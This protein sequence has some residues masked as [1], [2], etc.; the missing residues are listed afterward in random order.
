MLILDN[1]KFS[2][3]SVGELSTDK[4]Y[5]HMKRVMKS[6]EVIFVTNGTLYMEED[7]IQYAL[8]PN[9]ILVLEPDKFHRGY[10]IHEGGTAFYWFH[11]RT[12]NL[13]IPFKTYTG[14]EYH[15]V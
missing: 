13:P 7:G 1:T 9:Q 6:F 3:L 10:K 11:Y 2:F 15:E 12:D 14:N 5:I 8:T 4:P